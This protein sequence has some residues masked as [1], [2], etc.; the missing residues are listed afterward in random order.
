[1][2]KLLV[3][4][5]RT[6]WT[7]STP[8][9]TT[10]A[11]LNKIVYGDGTNFILSTPTVPLNASPGA[12]KIL[13]GDGTNFVLS[14]PTFPY[15]ASATSGKIIKSDGTNW[16]ASTE[17]YAAPGT[18]ANHLISDGTNWTAAAM[19]DTVIKG[20]GF[21]N[22][23]AGDSAICYVVPSGGSS[24]RSIKAIRTGGTA[25]VIN[26]TKNGSSDLLTANY[27]T[28]TSFAS[29]GTLQNNTSLAADDI[30]RVTVRSV[31]GTVT[32]VYIQILYDYAE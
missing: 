3:F 4:A 28:T 2:K 7:A 8:T 25:A 1:M 23:T 19:K 26:A 29:A 13:A 17:T 27:T 21:Y 22:I 32:E 10:T 18:A 11:T 12:G 15:S 9:H 16:V 5:L 24:I 14:T 31:T 30:I 20:F 6:N